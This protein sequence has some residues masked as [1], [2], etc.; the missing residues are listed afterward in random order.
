[1][2]EDETRHCHAE[3]VSRRERTLELCV[4]VRQ[5]ATEALPIDRPTPK[6]V[7]LR[8]AQRAASLSGAEGSKGT[9]ASRRGRAGRDTHAPRASAR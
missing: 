4:T 9:D 7:T 1:V 3:F 8:P 5:Q 6:R 2:L